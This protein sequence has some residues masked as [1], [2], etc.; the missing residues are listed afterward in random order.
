MPPW[1]VG[2]IGVVA[3]VG[4]GV[5]VSGASGALRR[6]RVRRVLAGRDPAESFAT[7]A[8]LFPALERERIALAYLW[9]Q[10]LVDVEGAPITASDDIWRDLEIDQGEADDKFESS[11]EWRGGEDQ[12]AAAPEHPVR[13]VRDLMEEVLAYG[14]EGYSR[15]ERAAHH[16][17]ARGR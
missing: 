2:L 17:A 10:Q 12:S 3:I 1:L 4:G 16:T 9:V 11:Y 6:R 14:Y 5:A 8:Q 15:V 7:C 13:T